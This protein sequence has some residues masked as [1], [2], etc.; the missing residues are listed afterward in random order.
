MAEVCRD[1]TAVG[2]PGLAFKFESERL[3]AGEQ[4]F[5]SVRLP[6]IETQRPQIPLF[7]FRWNL[8]LDRDQKVHGHEKS[9]VYVIVDTEIVTIKRGGCIG[10]A[11]FSPV[12][13]VGLTAEAADREIHGLAD[14]VQCQGAFDRR[15]PTVLEVDQ[16]THVGRVWKHFDVEHVRG[17]RVIV[18]S[19]MTE[20]DG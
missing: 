4:T 9:G 20:V 10:T 16:P 2:Y 18:H 14:T 12:S 11:D 3:P 19:L 13:E 8:S 7:R 17:H 1:P 15:R 6:L 5:R